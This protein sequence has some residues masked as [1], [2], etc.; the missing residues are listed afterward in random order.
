MHGDYFR[1]ESTTRTILP[2]GL[3]LKNGDSSNTMRTVIGRQHLRVSIPASFAF[4]NPWDA[5]PGQF[6]GHNTDIG[7][8][9][10]LR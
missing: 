1:D 4:G 6:R 10:K 2:P 7:K 9:E 5:I 8:P 3:P